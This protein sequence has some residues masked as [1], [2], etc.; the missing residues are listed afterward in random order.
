MPHDFFDTIL[1]DG[2]V[3]LPGETTVADIAI[4]DGKIVGIGKFTANQADSCINC[5]GLHVL[6]GIIDSQVHFS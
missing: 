5:A 3:V 2:T 4:K 6:P 1:K